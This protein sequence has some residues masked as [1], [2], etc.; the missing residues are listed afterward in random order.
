[1]RRPTVESLSTRSVFTRG[2]SL[3]VW[4]RRAAYVALVGRELSRAWT[5]GGGG[6]TSAAFFFSAAALAAF[7]LGADLQL[8]RDAGG[9]LLIVSLIVAAILGLEHM[10]QEDLETGAVDQLAMAPPP[11]EFVTLTK[12][13]A[14]V[15]TGL[16]LCLAISP[17]AAVMM[18]APDRVIVWALPTLAIA[19][20][21]IIGAGA[22]P[23]ALAAGT[24]RGGMLIAVLTPPLLAPTAILA[25]MTLKA[26]AMGDPVVALLALLAASSTVS[27]VIGTVG[28]AA[29]LRLHIEH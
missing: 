28:A 12:I 2:V 5:G 19:A 24:A 9:G 6:V 23:A 7:A 10:F 8:L 16:G 3:R 1:M 14:R 17:L 29:A 4:R 22:T 18:S 11:L 25:A 26:A 13:L 15:V 27:V 21:G 20:P